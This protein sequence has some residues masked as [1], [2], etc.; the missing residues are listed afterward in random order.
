MD[1]LLF[2]LSFVQ[3]EAQLTLPALKSQV[4]PGLSRL[5]IFAPFFVSCSFAFASLFVAVRGLTWKA[6]GLATLPSASMQFQARVSGILSDLWMGF[7]V[8][9]IVSLPILLTPVRHQ[10]LARKVS[11]C[12]ALVCIGLISCNV[13]YVEFFGTLMGL[14]H[15]RYLLDV[16][17][18]LS[19]AN[20]LLDWRLVG[21]WVVFIGV[22]Y[23]T[24]KSVVGL[25]RRAI[26]VF[27][28]CL[29]VGGIGSQVTKVH[30]NT[31]KI[32]WKTP[33][34]LRLNFV[35]NL[36][37]QMAEAMATPQISAA[38]LTL[39]ATRAGVPPPS[40][41]SMAMQIKSVLEIAP[42]AAEGVVGIDLK[43]RVAQQI[44]SQQPVFFFVILLE[45]FRPEDSGFFTPSLP[46]TYTPF[47]DSLAQESIVFENAFSAGGVTRAGQEAVFCGM[48][49]GEKTSAM[50]DIVS[51]NPTCFVNL[52]KRKYGKRSFG[53]WWHAGDYNFDSQGTFW[54]RRGFDFLLS[55]ENF[56]ANTPSSFWGYSDFA[57][58]ERFKQEMPK[59]DCSKNVQ[60]HLFLS[61]TNHAAWSLPTDTPADAAVAWS[62][63]KAV[64]PASLTTRYTD[65]A[66]L[67]L[68]TYLKDSPCEAC[69]LTANKKPSMWDRSVVFVV[70]DHG[71]LMPSQLHPQGHTW[72]LSPEKNNLAARSASH[73]GLILTGGFVSNTLA[74]TQ[75]VA[76]H[77]IGN[78]VS[79]ADIFPTLA[80]LAQ[81]G[82]VATPADSLFSPTRRFPV[83][84]DLGQHVYVPGN[85]SQEGGVSFSR[86]D[87]Q[88]IGLM[89]DQFVSS[90]EQKP[91]DINFAGSFFK[92]YQTLLLSGQ[93]G[94]TDIRSEAEMI[95]V[96]N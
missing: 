86:N 82:T 78:P 24:W 13:P 66:L 49:A 5:E 29:V 33:H 58:V 17:F 84:S 68:V 54:K 37:L 50:R 60:A 69:T 25:S 26:V 21:L 7:V 52:L 67:R 64:S 43:N 57:L 18:V 31:Q 76:P 19:S 12:L 83:I 91:Q 10:V 46:V 4:A 9:L 28:A 65:E 14:G 20:M 27:V 32:G 55:R 51:L 94:Q 56:A 39:L 87:F 53:A 72:D 1:S 23:F 75:T 3:G 79:Q 88:G 38:E 15:L 45:S 42:R 48:M 70:N 93:A 6:L 92:A 71:M 73:A 90:P 40:G 85:N 62:A 89:S 47:F 35:E 22:A 63:N 30:L 44:K 59:I 2:L 36:F 41:T 8:A 16:N 96:R 95:K 11:L 81:V 74:Q 61:V 77:R 34:I 80:E